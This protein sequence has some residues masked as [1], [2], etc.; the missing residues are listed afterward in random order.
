MT[1]SM[2][3]AKVL[4]NEFA[5]TTR[6]VTFVDVLGVVVELVSAEVFG[7]CVGLATSFEGT[8]KPASWLA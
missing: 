6:K 5:F 2:T 3:G 7:A 4:T 8:L 1:L